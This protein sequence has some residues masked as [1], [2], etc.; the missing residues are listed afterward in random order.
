MSANGKAGIKGI[1]RFQEC[2][3]TFRKDEDNTYTKI[4]KVL[5]RDRATSAIKYYKKNNPIIEEGPYEIVKSTV[6]YD[7]KIEYEGFG[8][9][10]EF[11]YFRKIP[12][13]SCVE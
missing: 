9:M 11:L 12:D 8:G 13:E 2:V 7:E 3:I 4:T 10:K 1:S 6:D 5:T